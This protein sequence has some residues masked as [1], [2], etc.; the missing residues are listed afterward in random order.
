MNEQVGWRGF[1]DR[2][3]REAP[4]YARWLPEMPRLAHQ[5]LTEL[6]AI[7][8]RLEELAQE[9]RRSNRLMAWVGAAA[10]GL[11]LLSLAQLV[12]QLLR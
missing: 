6:P 4:R 11:A 12:L 7:R 10:G 1:R 2:L 9:R 8:L 3:V 5:A